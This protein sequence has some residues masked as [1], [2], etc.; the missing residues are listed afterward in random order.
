MEDARTFAA[1]LPASFE[2]REVA[3]YDCGF[4]FY[5]AISKLAIEAERRRKEQ[6]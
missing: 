3:C 2:A 4:L 1:L 5:A 6:A